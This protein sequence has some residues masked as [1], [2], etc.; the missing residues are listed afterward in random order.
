MT[1]VHRI[2]L[3]VVD[4]DQVGATDVREVLEHTHYPNRC[5]APRVVSVETQPVEWD[6]DHPLNMRTTAAT[7]FAELFPVRA[8][9]TQRPT[10]APGVEEA[11]RTVQL[12]SFEY[13]GAADARPVE[14]SY[15]ALRVAITADKAQAVTESRPTPDEARR[16]ID[17][18]I[19]GYWD[20][21]GYIGPDDLPHKYDHPAVVALLRA[22]GVE[23]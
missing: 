4:H 20:R 17:A 7:A 13:G 12:R 19:M 15:D 9:Y 2:V 16:L 5:I 3:Y 18:A 11:I 1:E 14:A 10:P 21:P 23:A 8:E 6:D 22:L